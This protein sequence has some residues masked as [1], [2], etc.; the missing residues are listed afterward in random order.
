MAAISAFPKAYKIDRQFR[1]NNINLLNK[2]TTILII[3]SD[4]VSSRHDSSGVMGGVCKV[5]L[6]I[7]RN[8]MI[9]DY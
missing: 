8:V 6:V 4:I 2:T 1:F 7:H 9:Y 3:L 5:W